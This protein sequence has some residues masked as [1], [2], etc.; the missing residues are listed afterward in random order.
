MKEKS[1]MQPGS[2]ASPTP[3]AQVKTTPAPG[4]LGQGSRNGGMAP[5]QTFAPVNMTA[6]TAPDAGSSEQKSLQPP[7]PRMQAPPRQRQWRHN[8]SSS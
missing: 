5:R 8:Q 2:P 6:P 1:A 7:N 3:G 4:L